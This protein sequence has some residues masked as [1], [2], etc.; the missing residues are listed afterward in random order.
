MSSRCCAQLH[1]IRHPACICAKQ[2]PVMSSRMFLCSDGPKA[3]HCS[4]RTFHWTGTT[5]FQ[6]LIVY[7]LA[8]DASFAFEIIVFLQFRKSHTVVF[9]KA[10]DTSTSKSRF[11]FVRFDHSC[12][13]ADMA[14]AE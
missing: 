14:A 4:A 13:F 5:P 11:G 6:V 12:N 9:Q 1:I 7:I 8:S 3:S 2:S 10:T